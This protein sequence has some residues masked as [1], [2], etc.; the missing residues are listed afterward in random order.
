MMYF[1][2]IFC[3]LIAHFTCSVNL[4]VLSESFCYV[5]HL[6][7]ILYNCI[8]DHVEIV[9][10]ISISILRTLPVNANCNYA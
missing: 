6:I 3:I 4:V 1:M 8:I 9:I 7:I 10:R 2:Y 5:F